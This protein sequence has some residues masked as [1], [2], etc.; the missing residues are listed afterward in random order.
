MQC[1]GILFYAM[2]K[3][4]ATTFPKAEQL[5]VSREREVVRPRLYKMIKFLREAIEKKE[6]DLTCPICLERAKLPIF[7]CSASH[8]ICSA[9]SPMVQKCPECREELP[10][11]LSR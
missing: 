7:M 3:L 10:I 5:V 4:G 8:I 1:I 6:E 11:P 2:G 9:C